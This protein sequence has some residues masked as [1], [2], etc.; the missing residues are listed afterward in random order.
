MSKYYDSSSIK[1]LKG[2][3]AVRKRPGMYI[4]DTEDG[5]GLHHMVFE[6]VDNAIDEALAGYCKKIKVIIYKDNSVSVED[7]GRGIP[8]GIH[9]EEGISAAEVIM[10]ILH[11]GAKFDENSYKVSGGLHGVGISVVNALSEKLELTIK[12]EGKIYYQIYYNGIPKIPLKI[13][14]KTKENGTFIH[15]WPD[16]NIFKNENK[17]KYEILY[18]R[19]KELSFLNSG[20][21]IYLEDKFNLKKEKFINKG[22]IK[23]FLKFLLKNKKTIHQNIFYMSIDKENIN[24]CITLQW[25]TSFNEKIYCFTNNIPQNDGGTHLSSFR[26]AMTRTIN[27]FIEKEG[28]NKKNKNNIIGEDIRE[29]LIGIISIKLRNPKFSSQTKEKLISSEVKHVIESLINEKL[30]EFLLENPNDTKLIINKII[31][32]SK[33]RE[34]ARK[35]RE[36]TRYKNNIEIN[37]LSGK[38]SDCQ[39]KDPKIAELYLVEGDSAG[40]SAKQGRNR[41]NQ[42]ILPLKGKILNV[43]KASFEKMLSSQ[44]IITIISALGFSIVNNKICNLDKLRYN[45]IIIMTDA[46]VDGS[47]IRTL[48]LT[49]FYRKLPELIK[50][51]YLFIA[52]PPLFKIKKGKKEF[53]IK[54]EE[55]LQNFLLKIAIKDALLFTNKND[56]LSE[57]KLFELTNNFLKYQKIINKLEKKIP[58]K[59]LN[60]LIYQPLI[61]LNDIK[62]INSWLSILDKKINKNIENNNKYIFSI[63]EDN[64]FNLFK[65]NIKVKIYGVDNN[66]IIDDNFINSKEYKLILKLGEKIKEIINK[67]YF[68]I[69]KGE[70]NKYISSFEEGIKW[71]LDESNSNLYIQ[72]YKGLGEMNPNQLWETT[73]SPKNRRMLKV[74]LKHAILADKL[75]T[76]LMGDEVEPR[77]NF[78]EEN[79]L[80][81]S[82]L[83]I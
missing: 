63:K 55:S 30:I 59:F 18:K 51:E 1:I 11:A 46:D 12:R 47:H 27:S 13:I 65:I 43:E 80:N 4:G 6:I 17:F 35:A 78:I 20:I 15:F 75:F 70:K 48:I 14:G 8:T 34:A 31:Q 62:Y 74:T 69:K 49:F 28:Y 58:R 7:D 26:S 38:L 32:S 81:I 60:L 2:L 29:G 25:T 73:M 16:K 79:A 61:K 64:K 21:S 19:L 83:D 44:E 42:A 45:N 52:Q 23:D 53:F 10:T 54:D 40:G 66:Y 82:N 57:K 71:L 5:T 39:E 50:K 33:A 68:L 9:K 56:F 76:I 77:R 37:N 3:D 36:I 41:K 22:G 72:R 67:N 24:V